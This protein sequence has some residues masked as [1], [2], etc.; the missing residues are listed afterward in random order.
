[1]VRTKGI[2]IKHDSIKESHKIVNG[3]QFVFQMTTLMS[4][5]KKKQDK[6]LNY[7]N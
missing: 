1:M 7:L 4:E 3:L 6:I 5:T 2:P